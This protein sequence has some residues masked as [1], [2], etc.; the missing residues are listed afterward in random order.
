MA[1]KKYKPTSP[2]RRF[3]TAVRFDDLSRVEPEPSLVESLRK[4]GGRNGTGRMTVRHR[5]GGHKRRYR[6]IDFRRDKD[7]VPARVASIEYDP[8]R[9][10]RIARLHYRDGEKRYI[11]APTGLRVG[12]EVFSGVDAEAR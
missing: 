10:A 3:M 4:S 5:G 8:N 12:D 6:R 7:G 1:L 2:G 11:L 9:S